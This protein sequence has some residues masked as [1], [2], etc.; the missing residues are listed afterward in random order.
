MNWCKKTAGII[1]DETTIKISHADSQE[2][3][4]KQLSSAY[5]RL[6]SILN[7]ISKDL[8][9]LDDARRYLRKAPVIDPEKPTIVIA[10]APNV[11]KSLLV[12]KIS[13][14]KPKIAS[15]PFTTKGI[16]V[17]HFEVKGISFQVIDTPGLLDREME[18]RNE[19]ELKGILALR[20]LANVI[21]FILDPSEYCGYTM[22]SQA[23]ILSDIKARFSNT[24]IIEVENKS[25]IMQTDSENLKISAQEGEGIKELRDLAVS[26]ALKNSI[27]LSDM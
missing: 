3:I 21:V 27:E 5:G 18:K 7:Q 8:A 13:S 19:M 24:R 20:H 23:N 22:D 17:G 4:K 14:A 16:S 15:Y 2:Q 26:L 1:K 6:S 12:G 9:F 10:G 25:D 11:G